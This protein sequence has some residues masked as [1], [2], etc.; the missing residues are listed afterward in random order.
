[1]KRFMGLMMVA[2][3]SSVALMADGAAL[4]NK[5]AQCHG[6]AGEKSGMGKSKIIKDMSKADFIAAMKG[7]QD[8]SY[9]GGMKKLMEMQAKGLS[10]ADIGAIADHIIK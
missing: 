9:G 7:Y 8:G 5:C 1:M 10:E 4:Y 2:A 3:V 6:A